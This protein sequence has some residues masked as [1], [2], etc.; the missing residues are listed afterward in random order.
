MV[1]TMTR[2][3][4]PL[5]ARNVDTMSFTSLSM[6][7]CVRC[8]A[9]LRKV[10]KHVLH[11]PFDLRSK[12]KHP[13]TTTM[14]VVTGATASDKYYDIVGEGKFPSWHRATAHHVLRWKYAPKRCVP[15]TQAALSM[16]AHRFHRGQ[17]TTCA[18]RTTV[19][20]TCQQQEG[21]RRGRTEGW[22]EVRTEGRTE[23]RMERPTEETNG[24][25]KRR[26]Q[27][28]R[29]TEGTNRRDMTEGDKRKRQTEETNGG[30]KRTY[31]GPCPGG[32]THGHLG[33]FP[34]GLVLMGTWVRSLAV[35]ALLPLG[36]M[37]FVDGTFPPPT[38]SIVFGTFKTLTSCGSVGH[39]T[40]K[41]TDFVRP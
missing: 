31:L 20:D 2:N 35:C 36:T 11:K 5:W 6:S 32:L 3:S 34:D 24:G 15:R 16:N 29:Q 17:H 22:T 8:W 23:V 37:P 40:S 26:G 7:S 30:D 33:P 39:D 12:S 28:R 9:A 14:Y 13:H 27:T 38:P 21:R 4:Q 41:L 10:A 19:E 18:T 1:P 25:D